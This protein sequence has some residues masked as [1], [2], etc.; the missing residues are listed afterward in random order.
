MKKIVIDSDIC[1]QTHKC[2]MVPECPMGAISQKG[3]GL[4]EINHDECILCR[5]CMKICRMGA[6]REE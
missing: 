4:P 5:K 6:V 1:P 2:P 3:F